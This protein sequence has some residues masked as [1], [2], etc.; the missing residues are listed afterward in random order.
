MIKINNQTY[1]IQ[2][3]TYELK[4]L[5]K[6]QTFINIIFKDNIK[7]IYQKLLLLLN[8]DIEI[9]NNMFYKKSILDWVFYSEKNNQI[10][11]LLREEE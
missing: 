11:L 10:T 7:E 2:Y 1:N 8:K 6:P 9:S 5:P 3:Y 4:F